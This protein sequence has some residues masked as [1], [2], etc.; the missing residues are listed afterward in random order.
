M[1][2]TVVF[3]AAVGAHVAGWNQ[4]RDQEDRGGQRHRGARARPQE[5]AEDHR[6]EQ[7]HDAH[8]QHDHARAEDLDQHEARGEGAHDAA[9]RRERVHLA[10]QAAAVLEVAQ[11]ELDHDRRDHAQDQGRRQEDQRG[12]DDDAQDQDERA[13]D[14][15]RAA[16]RIGGIEELGRRDRRGDIDQRQDGQARQPTRGQQDAERATLGPAVGDAAAQVVADRDARQDNADDAGPGVQRHADVRRQD[17]P[18][19]QLQNER[20]GARDEDNEI[21]DVAV[22][23]LPGL[24]RRRLGAR[25][26]RRIGSL[27]Q[28]RGVGIAD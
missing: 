17:A 14:R 1:R 28:F 26:R 9:E 5:V 8:A 11:R 13:I 23:A 16:E 22:Q 3:E 4:Q 6:H 21:A 20:A 2:P 10:D 25:R 12:D 15:Q 19:D 18:G 27:T 24:A 7:Q